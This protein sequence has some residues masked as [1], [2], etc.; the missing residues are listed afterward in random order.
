MNF[1][2]SA[3]YNQSRFAFPYNPSLKEKGSPIMLLP[4]STYFLLPTSSSLMPQ[5]SSIF[6]S[7]YF[8]IPPSF[9]AQSSPSSLSLAP[10]PLSSLPPQPPSHPS[11]VLPPSSFSIGPS[12]YSL[13]PSYVLPPSSSPT[14]SL[15]SSSPLTLLPPD[16]PSAQRLLSKFF[17]ENRYPSRKDLE[18]LAANTKRPIRNLEAWFKNRRRALALKGELPGYKRKNKFSK[19]ETKILLEYFAQMNRPKKSDFLEIREKLNNGCTLQNIKNWWNHFKKKRA[20]E[21]ERERKGRQSGID[22][23]YQVGGRYYVDHQSN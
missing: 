23:V 22:M 11:L 21:I 10:L 12:S 4:P 15:P 7:S 16:F 14:S 19:E 2:P 17:K 9:Q 8:L 5:S 1:C 3:L 6:P 20:R 13:S 18:N